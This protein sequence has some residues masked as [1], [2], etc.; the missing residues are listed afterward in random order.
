MYTELNRYWV[1]EFLG[2]ASQ[3]ENEAG[4]VTSAMPP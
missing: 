4:S 1:G 2:F 3:L